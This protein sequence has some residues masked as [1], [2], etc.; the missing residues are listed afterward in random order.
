[1]SE[2]TDLDKAIK[3]AEAKLELEKL[4][5]P[6]RLRLLSQ[7]ALMN[8]S[9]EFFA[10]VRSAVGDETYEEAVADERLKLSKAQD[11]PGSLKYEIGGAMAPALALAPFTGGTSIPAT[12]GRYAI[13]TGAR[14]A[15]Q[16]AVQ[17][18]LSS[19]GRQEGDIVDRVTENVGDVVTSTATGAVLNPV[20]QKAGGKLVEGVTKIAEPL[21]RKIK[22]QLGKPVEDELARIAKTSRLS[23]DEIIEQIGLGKTIPEL[24][25]TAAAEVRGFYAQA[26]PAKETIAKSLVGRKSEG[27]TDVFARLQ[28]DLSPN[29]QVGNVLKF[30]RGSE[31]DLQSAASKNYEQIYKNFE[32]FKSNNLNLAVEEILQ[33]QPTLRGKLRSLMTGLGKGTPFEIKDGVLK[34]TQDIDLRTAEKI[35]GLLFDRTNQLFQKGD[36]ELG[37]VASDLEKNLR[38]I[39]DETSPDLSLARATWSKLKDAQKAFQDGQKVFTKSADEVDIIFERLVASGDRDAIDSFRAG[40]ASSIRGKQQ[41]RLGISFINNLG[42]LNTKESLILQKIYPDEAL[43]SVLDKVNLAKASIMAQTKIMGGSPTAETLAA[44]SRVGTVDDAY[45]FTRVIASGGTD[46]PAA[47]QLLKK[48]IPTKSNA[49]NQD[50]M[51]QVAELLVSTNKQLLRNALTNNEARNQLIQTVNQIA[52]RIIAGGARATVQQVTDLIPSASIISQSFAEEINPEDYRSI[53]D[54]SRDL[55]PQTKEKILGLQ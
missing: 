29:A 42:D 52:D 21:I 2:H 14:L 44:G 41:G 40:V 36:G 5:V 30:I 31:R 4:T 7:G 34:L 20:V 38:G 46:I 18:G 26:G 17:G 47:I 33:R 32:G 39:I 51:Q 22:G 43:D 10:M 54:L 3:L 53:Q 55:S 11:K 13:G 23:V 6:D 37:K 35:R 15:T 48:F 24:S 28:R 50:Q 49:L 1:M 27:V 16:G 19:V 12:V 8:F 9:D 25:E 45:A